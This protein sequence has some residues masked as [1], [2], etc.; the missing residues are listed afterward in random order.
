[1]KRQFCFFKLQISITVPSHTKEE[2]LKLQP[3]N[4]FN[5]SPQATKLTLFSF[6]LKMYQTDIRDK[7]IK[8][9]NSI[10]LVNQ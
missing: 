7:K 3:Y 2:K 9:N 8:Q 6:I 1:M 4:A 10:L 5:G